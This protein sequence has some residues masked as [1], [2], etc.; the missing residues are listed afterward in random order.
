[1]VVF[2]YIKNPQDIYAESFKRLKAESNLDILPANLQDI[3]IRMVHATGN[4]AIIDMMAFSN[5]VHE[6]GFN[7]LQRGKPILLRC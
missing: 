1:M 4:P 7:A 5:N 3:A 6:A 2:D